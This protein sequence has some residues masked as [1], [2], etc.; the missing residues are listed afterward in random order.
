MTL[1]NLGFKP[2]S[3]DEYVSQ[4]PSEVSVEES[5]RDGLAKLTQV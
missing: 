5:I 3:V 1:I 2:Q 4:L